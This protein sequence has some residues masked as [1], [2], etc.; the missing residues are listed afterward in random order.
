MHCFLVAML[1]L[2]LV[3]STTSDRSMSATATMLVSISSISPE[4]CTHDMTICSAQNIPTNMSRG[5]QNV[6]ISFTTQ[7]RTLT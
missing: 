2:N 1:V 6:E 7:R 4:S 3:V 5:S